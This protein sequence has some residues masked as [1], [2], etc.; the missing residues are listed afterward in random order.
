MNALA[1]LDAVTPTFE[2]LSLFIAEHG[3]SVGLD[4]YSFRVRCG[5]WVPEFEVTLDLPVEFT[6]GHVEVRVEGSGSTP[7]DALLA[8]IRMGKEGAFRTVYYV[9]AVSTP[10]E[11]PA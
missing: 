6:G 4:T 10:G 7:T 8:A 11:D 3:G 9:D 5:A 1:R 2:R